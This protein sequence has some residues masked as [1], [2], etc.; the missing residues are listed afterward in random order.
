MM[1]IFNYGYQKSFD[2]MYPQ[3]KA[4]MSDAKYEKIRK[5]YLQSRNNQHLLMFKFYSSAFYRSELLF[6]ATFINCKI[7][8]FIYVPEMERPDYSLQQYVILQYLPYDKIYIE[9]PQVKYS[10]MNSLHAASTKEDSFILSKFIDQ[11]TKSSILRQRVEKLKIDLMNSA[12]Y[13][14]ALEPA[15]Q[16]LYSSQFRSHIQSFGK[17]LYYYVENFKVSST[18]VTTK[19]MTVRGESEYLFEG[20]EGERRGVRSYLSLPLLS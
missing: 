1:R 10:N 4:N 19:R 15:E 8:E 20:G 6:L 11:I 13:S 16:K 12:H 17:E 2:T 7:D 9:I 18:S 14:V 3:K 5:A